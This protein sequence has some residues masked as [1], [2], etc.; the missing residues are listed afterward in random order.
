MRQFGLALLW[1][2]ALCGHAVGAVNTGS[3]AGRERGESDEYVARFQNAY[4][5][6]RNAHPHPVT[7]QPPLDMMAMPHA[8][9]VA[10]PAFKAC[11]DTRAST[12][13]IMSASRC[14]MAALKDVA[15]AEGLRDMDLFEAFSATALQMAA[16]VD[17][18]K[19]RRTEYN[20]AYRTLAN[21]YDLAIRMQYAEYLAARA[22]PAQ[23]DAPPFDQMALAA[24]E[25]ALKQITCDAAM[26]SGAALATCLIARTTIFNTAIRVSDAAP[27][28]IVTAAAKRSGEA[29]DAGRMT[30]EELRRGYD[31]LESTWRVALQIERERWVG[32]SYVARME[33]RYDAARQ[34]KTDIPS[35]DLSAAAQ[36]VSARNQAQ[37][38]CDAAQDDAHPNAW[39]ECYLTADKVFA[40]ALKMGD[41]ALYDA[42]DA[43]ARQAGTEAE[44]G[45]L[46]PA[47]L[48]DAYNAMTRNFNSR[49]ERQ[50]AD[51]EASQFSAAYIA[52]FDKDYA[53]HKS[54]AP[55]NTPG[56]GVPPYDPATADTASLG[57]SADLG[58]C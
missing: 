37:T 55:A 38:L 33:A 10:E 9:A 58:A 3:I 34:G 2:L 57:L 26:T 25:A 20:A 14:Y 48:F 19:L 44:A 46:T 4:T 51:Y 40:A 45:K 30:R 39:L 28:G 36:A 32:T 15:I 31:V 47:D 6:M 18:G 16:D 29:A 49:L 54:A 27:F 8:L 13:A 5:A 23:G 11:A 50:S 52:Q 53:A 7:D 43:T 1:V 22:K 41:R 24:A 17:A 56:A 42:F 12:E 35:L 21:A